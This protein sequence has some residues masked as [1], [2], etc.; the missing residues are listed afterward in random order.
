MKEKKVSL[1]IF[2]VGRG[3]GGKRG[4][5]ERRK[6]YIPFFLLLAVVMGGS[7]FFYLG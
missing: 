7:S 3:E 1:K 4:K 5:N 6:I 2:I